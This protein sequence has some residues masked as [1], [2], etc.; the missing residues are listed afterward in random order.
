MESELGVGTTFTLVLP[1]TQPTIEGDA[2]EKHAVDKHGN[3]GK[4]RVRRDWGA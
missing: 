1:R 2:L 4:S 3:R